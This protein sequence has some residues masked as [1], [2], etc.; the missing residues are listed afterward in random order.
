M[1]SHPDERLHAL[2]DESFLFKGMDAEVRDRIKAAAARARF[3]AGD[4]IIGEGEPGQDL[5]IVD[6]GQIE[7]STTMV[8]GEVKLAVLD[9][10]AVVGEVA[11]ITGAKRTSTVKALTEVEAIAIPGAVVKQLAEERPDLKRVLEKLIE[12]RAR[13]TISMIPK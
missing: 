12:G 7:V 8:G 11:A 10:G 9:S 6:T 5:V 4:V 3:M 13:H 1:T 2:V